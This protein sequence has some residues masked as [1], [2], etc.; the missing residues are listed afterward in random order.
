[1]RDTLTKEE[2]DLLN[3]AISNP[4]KY[5]IEVDNDDIFVLDLEADEVAGDFYL[6]GQDLIVALLKHIGANANFV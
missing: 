4:N 6:Y 1:M 2:V 5:S 3:K